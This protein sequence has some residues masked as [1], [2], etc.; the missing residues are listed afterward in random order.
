M[1]MRLRVRAA[2]LL[3]FFSGAAGTG[4]VASD[5]SRAA[6]H[7][8]HC[9][10][11]AG[12]GHASLFQLAA[13]PALEGLFDFVDR[14][15]YLPRRLATVAI[16]THLRNRHARFW[17]CATTVHRSRSCSFAGPLENLHRSEEHTSELQSRENLVCRLLL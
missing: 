5:L 11:I 13:F 12:T 8:L 10:Q 6:H 9:L 1:L 17:T 2:A 15:S 4:V 14:R 16:P 7:L 3:I